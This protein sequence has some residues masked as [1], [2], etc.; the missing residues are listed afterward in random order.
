M[1]ILLVGAT[2]QVGY[3]LAH[4]LT[5][6]GHETTVLVR[7]ASRRR[8]FP[9]SLRVVAESNFTEAL[10]ARLL[11]QM[12]CAIYDVGLP[13]QFTF[14]ASIFERVNL[15]LLRTFLTAMEKST[16]RRL[17]YISTYEVFSA[18]G[19]LI[20]E[21]HPASSPEGL[22]PYF[23][24]M[25]RAYNEAAFVCRAH[26]HGTHHHPPCGT[27]WWPQHRRRFYQCD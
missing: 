15:Q 24:A 11:P 6:A 20:R 8:R 3:A 27:L 7:D 13:E 4:A 14:D 21:S 22:T 19:G 2:G 26:R 1:K 18:Q 16:L 25:T 10:F 5:A 12:D 17:V 9:E 23:A